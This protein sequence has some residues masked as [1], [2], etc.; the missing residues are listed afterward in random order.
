MESQSAAGPR[1]LG[2]VSIGMPLYNIATFK[3]DH[4]GET[5]PREYGMSRSE[6]LNELH[7]IVSDLQHRCIA[8][9]DRV[10]S[11][12]ARLRTLIV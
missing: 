11:K 8:A 10:R 4:P 5:Y 3:K 9:L 6:E 12:N 7:G 1:D 2:A